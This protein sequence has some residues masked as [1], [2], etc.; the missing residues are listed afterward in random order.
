MNTWFTCKI[1]Y[2]KID[3]KGKAKN[4]SE[5]YLVDAVSF[6][7]AERRIYE[8]MESL[9]QGEFYV[10]GIAK[11]KISDVFNYEDSYLWHRCKM[12]YT[13]EEEGKGAEKKITNYVLL[14]APNVKEAYDR[15]YQSLNNMLVDFRVT[16]IV[17]SPIVE[18][19]PYE[20]PEEEDT[21]FQ[22]APDNYRPLSEVNEDQSV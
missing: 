5:M 17:E 8:K 2:Q 4:V 15:M 11:A 14:T 18:V 22:E 20:S 3:E 12:V 10:T 21:K 1:K 6:T 9:I 16:E 19:F 13:L 7:E